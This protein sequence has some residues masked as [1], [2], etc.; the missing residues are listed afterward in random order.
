MTMVVSR[1]HRRLEDQLLPQFHQLLGSDK[2]VQGLELFER[3]PLEDA[4]KEVDPEQV[5]SLVMARSPNGQVLD[6]DL[7]GNKFRARVRQAHSRAQQIMRDREWPPA[8]HDYLQAITYW[9]VAQ[10]EVGSDQPSV[11]EILV[12]SS[13][14]MGG[15]DQGMQDG[16]PTRH[17]IPLGFKKGTGILVVYVLY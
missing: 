3:G 15:T 16:D 8:L 17:C 4:I 10:E 5:F 11:Y 2:I 13:V 12:A 9:Q 7:S 14:G 1:Y 6:A